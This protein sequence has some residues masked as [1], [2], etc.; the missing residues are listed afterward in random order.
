MIRRRGTVMY[1]YVPE[2]SA[3]EDRIH[4]VSPMIYANS[5]PPREGICSANAAN[6]KRAEG[7]SDLTAKVNGMKEMVRKRRDLA[8]FFERG[9]RNR[10]MTGTTSM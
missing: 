5:M 4:Q 8:S 1:G 3:W 7:V 10:K 9:S 2:Q 6:L